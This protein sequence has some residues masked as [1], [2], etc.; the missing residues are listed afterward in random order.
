MT[1]QRHWLCTAAM[2]L[3]PVSAPQSGPIQCSPLL[4]RTLQRREFITLLGDLRPVVTSPISAF[5]SSVSTVMHWNGRT[6][7]YM[8]R[9]RRRLEASMRRCLPILVMLTGVTLLGSDPAAAY[10]YGEAPWC[11]LYDIGEGSSQERCEFRDFESCRQEITGGNRG[12]CNH[13]PRWT[14]QPKRHSPPRRQN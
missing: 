2:V 6:G 3:M 1:H 4:K 5:R 9:Q 11:A 8:I 12:F 7:V 13:N 14:G 10:G